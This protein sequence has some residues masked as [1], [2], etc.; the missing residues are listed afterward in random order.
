M[1]WAPLKRLVS[2]PPTG[3]TAFWAWFAATRSVGAA[4]GWSASLLTVRGTVAVCSVASAKAEAG[5]PRNNTMGG[6][7][8]V[9]HT[10]SPT[11]MCLS[12]LT[13]PQLSSV[14]WCTT[15]PSSQ[16]LPDLVRSE[17]GR[18]RNIP[19]ESLLAG[20]LAALLAMPSGVSVSLSIGAAIALALSPVTVPTLWRDKRGRWLLISLVAL[21]PSGWLVAQASLLQDHG[22]T[23][24][25]K[26]FL[27]QAA[28]PV[29]LLASV[30]G[31]YW[32]ITK[33]GLQRFL[34]ISFAGQLAAEPIVNPMLYVNPWKCGLALPVSML[35]ILLFAR[36]RFL[37]VLV[38]TPLLVAVSI[39]ADFRSWTALL[40]ISTVLTVFTGRRSTQLSTSRMASLWFVTGAA[41]M[42]VA[43]LITQAST[44]GML[45]EYLQRRTMTQLANTNGN[46]LLGG[47]PEWG[48]A[49]A[50]WRESPLGL[51]IGVSPSSDDYWLAI[52]SLPLGS[53]AQQEIHGVARYFREGLV[54]FHSTLWT[55]WA[56]YGAA[57]VLFT[58][59]ALACAA[60]A[61]MTATAGTRSTHL[62]A[63][64]AL[65]MLSCIWDLLFSPTIVSL[66][67]IAL[68]TALHILCGPRGDQSINYKDPR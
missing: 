26:I 1:K 20:V 17:G 53:F 52:R 7:H 41:S 9:F 22:R 68:A 63:S 30:V 44:A 35:V 65:L 37:L 16:R 55:F 27:F 10:S 29:G 33:L 67:A 42:A 28:L 40:F 64:V 15:M 19:I 49:I 57:G 2:D 56:N 43:W 14:V 23:F 61:T 62:R 48:A 24:S 58:V 59:L 6:I 12:V 3:G 18:S 38:A 8:T 36:S 25:S 5:I 66:L 31:A 47:R 50:L 13:L 46:L 54:S 11:G 39:A 21:V 51:G 32:C 34:L 60:R 4:L 45:G